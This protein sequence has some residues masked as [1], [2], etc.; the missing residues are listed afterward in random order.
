MRSVTAAS[1][2]IAVS[3]STEAIG[4]GSSPNRANE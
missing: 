4:V 3:G 2:A 1:P